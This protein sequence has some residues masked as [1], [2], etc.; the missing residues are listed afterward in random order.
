METTD[1]C[2]RDEFKNDPMCKNKK[3]NI[4]ED[5]FWAI[6]LIAITFFSRIWYMIIDRGL[7]YVFGEEKDNYELLFL[8]IVSFTI[9]IILSQC[10]DVDIRRG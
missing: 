9:I 4:Y 6:V 2:K 10:F 7:T 3:C 1:I 5:I 8:G